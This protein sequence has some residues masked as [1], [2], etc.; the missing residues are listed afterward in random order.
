MFMFLRQTKNSD[1]HCRVRLLRQEILA[2]GVRRPRPPRAA[3][4][5]RAGAQTHGG[6]PRVQR[7]GE[8]ARGRS[9]TTC[10]RSLSSSTSARATSSTAS[11]PATRA[12]SGRRSRAPVRAALPGDDW[13]L[14]LCTGGCE[15]GTRVD[16]TRG[17]ALPERLR[18][19]AGESCTVSERVF[20]RA[21]NCYGAFAHWCPVEIAGARD[22]HD[23]RV[24]L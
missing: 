22:V 16:D 24:H 15:R 9:S 10:A 13:L 11:C 19:Q 8:A 2:A 6:A 23:V 5:L 20:E 4:D 18:P 17:Y 12:P 7:R 3:G 1:Q 14:A 21:N